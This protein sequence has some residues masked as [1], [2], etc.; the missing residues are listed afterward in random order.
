MALPYRETDSSA[1]HLI[2][3][4]KPS[5]DQGQVTKAR[6]TKYLDNAIFGLLVVFAIALPHS[7]KGAERSWKIALVLWL[8]KLLIDRARPD[9]P[10][11]EKVL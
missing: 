7:I 2:V 6:W 11:G 3:T 5:E 8:L 9:K 4:G 1:S 10:A